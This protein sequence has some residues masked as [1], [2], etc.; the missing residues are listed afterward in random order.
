MRFRR[1]GGNQLLGFIVPPGNAAHSLS[2]NVPIQGVLPN[3]PPVDLGLAVR[4]LYSDDD[5]ELFETMV[6]QLEACVDSCI[7]PNEVLATPVTAHSIFLLFHRGG[8][9]EAWVNE[10]PF[11]YQVRAKRDVVIGPTS[12]ND[13]GD[14]ETVDLSSVDM[15]PGSG[16]AAVLCLPGTANRTLV[17]DLR[18]LD[19]EWDGTAWDPHGLLAAALT[20]VVFRPQVSLSEIE[21]RG[22]IAQGLFPFMCLDIGTVNLMI[23]SIRTGA[24]MANVIHAVVENVRRLLPEIH[25]FVAAHVVY[26]RHRPVLLQAIAAYERGEYAIATTALLPR[27]EGIIRDYYSREGEKTG[28]GPIKERHLLD[29]IAKSS[30]RNPLSLLEPKRFAEYLREVMFGFESF[31]NP[32][33][34]TRVTRHSVAHGVAD[35]AMLDEKAA[36]MAL[37]TLYQTGVMSSAARRTA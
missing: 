14:I 24:D 1:S 28:S 9:I 16:F 15:P 12:V 21:W 25:A 30:T 35:A 4:G 29:T 13:I 32:S 19:S 8:D 23:Q 17:F 6:G 10:L 26:E 22:L 31:A 37:L 36:A 3:R 34:V 7:P 2:E 33:A 11:R 5:G 27:M 18:P 20:H